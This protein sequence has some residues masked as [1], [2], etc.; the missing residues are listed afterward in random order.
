M[1]NIKTFNVVGIDPTRFWKDGFGLWKEDGT[2]FKDD[3]LVTLTKEE[4]YWVSV[5]CG[6]I[7]FLHVDLENANPN[8]YILEATEAELSRLFEEEKITGY[9]I[10]TNPSRLEG[11]P[12]S[13]TILSPEEAERLGANYDLR[14]VYY[15]FV[16]I[17][18]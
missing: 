10:I 4:A 18:Q 17:K 6:Q 2:V 5:S 12:E 7:C 14:P 1:E 13:F 9:T 11:I 15:D 8:G 3:I 16:Y